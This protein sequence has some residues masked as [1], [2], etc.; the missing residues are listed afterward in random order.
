[1]W[2]YICLSSHLFSFHKAFLLFYISFY[3]YAL[4]PL[5]LLFPLLELNDFISLDYRF[6]SYFLNINLRPS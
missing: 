4:P 1:M 6:Y 2:G 3:L 5:L